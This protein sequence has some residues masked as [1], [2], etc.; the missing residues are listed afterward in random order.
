MNLVP[1]QAISGHIK[2]KRQFGIARNYLSQIV[3]TCTFSAFHDKIRRPVGV[4][5]FVFSKVFDMI[6]QFIFISRVRY[7][8]GK[9]IHR[10]AGKV[11]ELLGSK[12]STELFGFYLEVYFQIDFL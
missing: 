11:V 2:E 10:M 1:S 7:C 3:C 4:L 8:L 9:L 5:N 12:E 6:F